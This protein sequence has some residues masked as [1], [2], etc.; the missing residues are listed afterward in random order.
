M[1]KKLLSVILVMKKFFAILLAI[2][3]LLGLAACQQPVQSTEPSA[4]PSTEATQPTTPPTT[5]P[6]QEPT[7][8][9]SDPRQGWPDNAQA[10]DEVWAGSEIGKFLPQPDVDWVILSSVPG[11]YAAYTAYTTE[12][13]MI[14]QA[15]FETQLLLDF[16]YQV[17]LVGGVYIG[18]DDQGYSVM[19]TKQNNPQMRRPV[20]AIELWTPEY[21]E[22][23]EKLLD[24]LLYLSVPQH[25]GA[26]PAPPT[27]QWLYDELQY[28]QYLYLKNTDY[29]S[30]LQY[31]QS[32]QDYG[33]NDVKIMDDN[34]KSIVFKAT[35]Q[36]DEDKFENGVMTTVKC[37]YT[38]SV[39]FD[40][41][42][43]SKREGYSAFVCFNKGV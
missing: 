8:Q 35:G 41:A 23:R 43:N 39:E 1:K 13:Q 15:Y 30:I 10:T 37:Y 42:E 27:E 19:V 38:V 2:G 22:S 3:I 25:S 26:L 14:L 12:N 34:G 32:L 28:K 21:D 4:E 24:Q 36:F 29:D 18:V 31:I 9:T 17:A 7:E 6:T 33:Y 40:P 11:C 5:E 16:N 20:Y